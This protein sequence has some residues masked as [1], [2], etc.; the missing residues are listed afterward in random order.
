MKAL[1]TRF[2]LIIAVLIILAALY[3]RFTHSGQTNDL[4]KSLI[5]LEEVSVKPLELPVRKVIRGEL[6]QYVQAGGVTEAVNQAEVKAQ[7]GGEVI[8]VCAHNGDEVS[9]GR[10]VI[11]LDNRRYLATLKQCESNLVRA[12]IEYSLL[13]RDAGNGNHNAQVPPES[14]TR[15]RQA[16]IDYQAGRI[17]ESEWL[18]AKRDRMS[19][20]IMAGTK[21]EEALAQQ[22]GLASAEAQYELASLDAEHC[23]IKAPFNGVIGNCDIHTGETV[24][25]GQTL[26]SLVDLSRLDIK[27]EALETDIGHIKPG[28]EVKLNFP[29]FADR[30][31]KARIIGVNPLVDPTTRTCKVTARLE[32][33]E[34]LLK[35]GMYGTARMA[36]RRYSD[37]LLV[38]R[39]AVLVRDQRKLVFAVRNGKAFWCYVE[40]GLENDD[41]IEVVSS[42][43]DLKEG[44]SV[45]VDGHFALAHDTPVTPKPVED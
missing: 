1:L 10:I 7:V 27:L 14:E 21:Q 18:A 25:A 40:T 9:A 32:N 24:T 13:K 6:I 16:E 42:T 11:R 38:P 19:A 26:F 37:K 29:A 43:F 39:A 12:Q 5:K 34:G 8:E 31:F 28:W 33:P 17:T 2:G 41:W 3:Y 4:G 30:H 45:I 44:E 35:S 15:Y 36:V 22:S 23:L 20:G